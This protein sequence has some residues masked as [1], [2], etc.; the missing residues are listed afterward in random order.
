MHQLIYISEQY[1]NKRLDNISDYLKSVLEAREYQRSYFHKPDMACYQLYKSGEDLFA[2][3]NYFVGADWLIRGKVAIFLESKLNENREIDLVGMLLSSLEDYE[4]IDHLDKLF[5]VDYDQEWID[6][7]GRK[8]LLSPFLIIQ[9]LKLTQKIVRKGL[10]K[11]YY[12]VVENL[13]S[14]I[15]G[16]ILVGQQIKHN[17]SRDKPT[18]TMCSY[19][20]Y[21]IDTTENQFLKLVL[22]F[23]SS[24]MD[25]KKAIFTKEQATQLRSILNFCLPAFELVSVMDNK[26]QN[27]ISK[28]NIFYNEYIKAIEIG[29]YILKRYSFNISKTNQTQTTTPPFWIDMSKLFELFVFGKLKKVFPMPGDVTY[30][31]TFLGGKE[32]D[33]LIRTHDY[34]CVIDCK[35]KPQYG[36]STPSLDDKRQLAG[37]T[38]LKSVYNRLSIPHDQ[39]IRGVIIYPCQNSQELIRK[40]CL[41][42]TG[43]DEYVSFYIF[44]IKLPEIV[45][46]P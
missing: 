44:G 37:Y 23:V 4:N 46:Y 1:K 13:N 8:D 33:I 45:P 19:Q 24:Y 36:Y 9:F 43:I 29:K 3:T 11:S 35:Y 32:T 7:T 39:L 20:L 25:Q 28:P 17:L 30:H 42:A 15:K 38:R 31:D 40:D 5:H 12:H 18:M 21:G 16:K 26:H 22:Q 10:K 6:I 34:E 14:R 41:F 2:N 27:I